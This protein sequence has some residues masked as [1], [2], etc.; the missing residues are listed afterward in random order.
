M[1]PQKLTYNGSWRA[2]NN[3]T[4]LSTQDQFSIGGRHTVR[5]FDGL[6]VL[7]AER[8]WTWRNELVAPLGQSGQKLYL[9]IDHGRVSGPSAARVPNQ[10][11][12]G[13]AIG[14][15]GQIGPLQ[16]DVFAGRPLQKPDNL[17]TSRQVAGFAISANF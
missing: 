6:S 2:Q 12:T 9:A 16:F 8:G 14:L 1:G 10:H 4:I 13:S 3:R 5:G 15:R 17:Q 7:S 11:L